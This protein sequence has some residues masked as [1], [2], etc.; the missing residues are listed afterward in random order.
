[1]NFDAINCI[2]D[3]SGYAPIMTNRTITRT[4]LVGALHKEVGLSQTDCTDLLEGVLNEITKALVTGETVK[5]NNFASFCTKHKKAR[6][7]RNVT[8]GEE[9]PITPRRVITFTPSLKLKHKINQ[10]GNQDDKETS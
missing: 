3:T 9:V 10:A 7:G 2:R 8:T 5:I 4:D 1:L 6:T